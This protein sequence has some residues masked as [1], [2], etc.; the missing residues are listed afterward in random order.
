MSWKIFVIA[1]LIF[2]PITQI[3]ADSFNYLAGKIF[4]QVEENG[5]AWY[6]HPEKGT[7]FYLKDGVAAYEALRKFGLGITDAD[8]SK[9]QIGSNLLYGE[10]D[11][12]RDR[13]AD[14]LENEIGTDPF[15]TDTDADGYSDK[16][17]IDNSYDPLAPN[18]KMNIDQDLTERLKGYILLQVESHGQAW[19]V[20]PTDGKRYYMRN[21]DSA[22]GLMSRLGVGI[23]NDDLDLIETDSSSPKLA[24]HEWKTYTY[25]QTHL[26]SSITL[27][28]SY[29]DKHVVMGPWKRR[30]PCELC[31][32]KLSLYEKGTETDYE[33]YSTKSE[34]GFDG[35]VIL[36][37]VFTGHPTTQA[38]LGEHA[39]NG[40][41]KTTASGISGLEY[42][43]FGPGGVT[44]FVF[45]TENYTF[46]I[47]DL[48]KNG[49]YPASEWKGLLDSLQVSEPVLTLMGD[50][51]ISYSLN[52]LPVGVSTEKVAFNE[53]FD[54]NGL[55]QWSRGCQTNKGQAYFDN[56]LK[57]FNGVELTKY[58]FTYL[59]PSQYPTYTLA[60]APNAAQYLTLEEFE[61]DFLLCDPLGPG[62][63]ATKNLS[64]NNLLFEGG[65][66]TGFDDGSGRVSGCMQM[67]QTLNESLKLE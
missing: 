38:F 43:N 14:F 58:T 12:D 31:A 32:T 13:L 65:C 6:V 28:F 63:V 23:T 2:M 66:G 61:S 48:T 52:E 64:A 67:Q 59:E 57:K 21:G 8:I 26:D 24:V 30:A 17:E 45:T 55:A 22:H 62:E 19:Y 47:H 16:I 9:I 20:N 1:G 18:A 53:M 25:S 56:L 39:K 29:P 11:T 27:T 46:A 54:S 3:S 35:G 51:I 37:K 36:I 60:T 4:L 44:A 33:T 49:S 5:E 50:G 40:I 34:A 15:N 7:R 41:E 10:I 42:K